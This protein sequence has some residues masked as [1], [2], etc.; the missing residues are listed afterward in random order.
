MVNLSNMNDKSAPRAFPWIWYI[1]LVQ[2]FLSVVVLG[3]AA[4]NASALA[5]ITCGVPAKLGYNIACVWL[6]R[7]FLYTS[8]RLTESVGCPCYYC[9]GIFY[10]IYRSGKHL[11]NPTMA[12]LVSTWSRRNYVCIV[13]GG[14]RFIESQ[15]QRSLQGM[16]SA[17]GA[18]L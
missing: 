2:I 8:L 3:L 16:P 6:S 10:S 13:V 17:S 4:A 9:P 7:D 15:L 14:C 18:H 12:N 5:D 11:Q 1:R